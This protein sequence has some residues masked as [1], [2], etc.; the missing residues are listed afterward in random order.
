MNTDYARDAER[1]GYSPDDV[2]TGECYAR[3][4]FTDTLYRVTA[5]VE[6]RDGALV[7]LKKEVVEE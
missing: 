6:G 5:W 1:L 3:S 4:P 2:R 7:A